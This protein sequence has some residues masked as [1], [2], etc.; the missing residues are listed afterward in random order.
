VKDIPLFA[1]VGS[2]GA[3]PGLGPCDATKRTRVLAWLRILRGELS[4]VPGLEIEDKWFSLAIHHRHVPSRAGGRAVALAAGASLDGA[5]VIAGRGVVNVLPGEAPHK[6]TA[7]A[8]LSRRAGRRPVFYVG[9]DGSDEDAFRSSAV[10]VSVRV[11]RTARS[12]AAWYV[13]GEEA[14][15]DMLRALIAARTRRDGLGDR[16]EGVSRAVDL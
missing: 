16:T 9:D 6:G 5:R 7:I 15:D 11:G 1:V 10:H 3:E 8:E 13:P 2:H 14:V 12:S 4:L